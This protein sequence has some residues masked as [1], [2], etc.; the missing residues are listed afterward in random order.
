MNDHIMNN[1]NVMRSNILQWIVFL[2]SRIHY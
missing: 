1:G 2:L